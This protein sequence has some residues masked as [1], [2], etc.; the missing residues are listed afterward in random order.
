MP[1][2]LP[3]WQ[4]EC[5]T[6]LLCASKHSTCSSLLTSGPQASGGAGQGVGEGF[7]QAG[8]SCLAELRRAGASPLFCH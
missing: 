2:A 4:L 1:V 6:A 7:S 5:G 8:A 3:C